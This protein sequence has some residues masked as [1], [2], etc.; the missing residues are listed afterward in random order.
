LVFLASFALLAIMHTDAAGAALQMI[1]DARGGA[2]PPASDDVN[3]RAREPLDGLVGP[4]PDCHVTSIQA[5]RVPG[6]FANR[7]HDAS[8]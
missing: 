8:R 6:F 5:P 4:F 2:G 1:D 3:S 7:L